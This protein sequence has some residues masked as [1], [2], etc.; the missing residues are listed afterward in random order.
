VIPDPNTA[1]GRAEIERRLARRRAEGE[2]ALERAIKHADDE[3]RG[4]LTNPSETDRHRDR[5]NDDN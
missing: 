2:A 4:K 5:K 1:E 3:P